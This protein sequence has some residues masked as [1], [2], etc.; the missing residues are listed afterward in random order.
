MKLWLDD[1]VNDP[2]TPSRH[3]P[4]GWLGV[5]SALEACRLLSRGGVTHVSLD[6][7]LGEGRITGYTV[8]RF[9]EKWSFGGRLGPLQWSV[10]SA[11]PVGARKMRLALEAADSFWGR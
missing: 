8:A 4:P 11:N 7:D 6:H 9:I 5:P 2:D 3:P 1:Q 10:H